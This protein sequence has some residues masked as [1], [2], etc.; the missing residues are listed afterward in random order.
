M[1]KSSLT[2]NM[3]SQRVTINRKSLFYRGFGLF[4]WPEMKKDTIRLSF[5]SFMP[6]FFPSTY[7]FYGGFQLE[8]VSIS[9]VINHMTYYKFE[10]S[11]WWKI[12]FS[13]KYPLQDLLSILNAVI[14]TNEST[15]IYN[16][17]CDL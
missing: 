16:R 14:S 9:R 11:H 17:S 2:S 6:D 10:C 15:Q 1:L 5:N 13:K 4:E 3:S 7:L 12:Y 8:F